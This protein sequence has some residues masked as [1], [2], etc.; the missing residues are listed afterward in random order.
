[1]RGGGSESFWVLKLAENT[2][3]ESIA[4][5]ELA[6]LATQIFILVLAICLTEWYLRKIHIR[7]VKPY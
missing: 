5:T 6:G 1:M 3:N 2:T 4:E 7:D